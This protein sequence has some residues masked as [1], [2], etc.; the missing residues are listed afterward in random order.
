M[1]PSVTRS[2][3]GHGRDG[4]GLALDHHHGETVGH[5]AGAGIDAP[6]QLTPGGCPAPPGR[7]PGHGWMSSE[8]MLGVHLGVHKNPQT[9]RSSAHAACRA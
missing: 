2:K 4:A 6:A 5:P 3:A 1:V 9:P 7:E 8:L